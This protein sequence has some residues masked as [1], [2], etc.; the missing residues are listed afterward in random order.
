[1]TITAVTAITIV[2]E[3]VAL[4]ADQGSQTYLGEP[5]TMAEHML[6]TAQAAERGG[7]SP[8]LVVAALLHD[9]GHL[10]HGLPE[11][12][13]DHGVDTA[14]ENVGARWLER[15]F[16]REVTEPIRLHVAAKQYLCTT[17]PAYLAVLSQASVHSLL[18]QG[19]PFSAAAVAE[20]DAEPY[21]VDAVCLRRW[22]DIGKVAGDAT[23]SIEHYRS[24]LEA[25]TTC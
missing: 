12:S 10:V 9:F 3:I 11:H 20:F 24:L 21:A 16:G 5:V 18:L 4:F 15:G 13:A 25:M 7:A 1:M 2:D 6:Q 19:G 14:H 22:D 8:A 23:P 17:D